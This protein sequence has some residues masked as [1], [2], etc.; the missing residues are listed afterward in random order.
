[1]C[2]TLH[3][4]DENGGLQHMS[5]PQTVIFDLGGTLLDWPDWNEDVSRRWAL[6]YDYLTTKMP[7][8]NWPDRNAYVR[9]MLEAEQAH[10]QRVAAEQWSGPPSSLLSD[11][12][13]RLGLH[14][15]EAEILV[16]L[17]GYARAV[18]GWAVVFPD[19]RPTLQ[20]LRERG[21]RIGLLSNTWWAAEWHNADLA[22][23]GLTD[24]LDE[25]AYTSDLPH[26]KPHPSVF[27]D[28]ARRLDVEPTACVMVGDRMIDDISGALGAGMRAIW[29]R[30]DYPWP[31]PEHIHPTATITYLA[32][33]PELLRSWS[34]R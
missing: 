29:K 23:H 32:E 1:V 6:S 30:T 20:S 13:R 18:D 22:A 26:S 34:G 5:V 2:D 19:T 27:L 25:V 21:Y 9:A 4:N 3:I 28:V 17:D 16:A 15:H 11:G 31:K 10:W 33:L 7:V 14:V 24:L 12:F 8:Y